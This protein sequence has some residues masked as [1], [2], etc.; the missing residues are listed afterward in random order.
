MYRDTASSYTA[1]NEAVHGFVAHVPKPWAAAP[2]EHFVHPAS[3]PQ[4]GSSWRERAPTDGTRRTAE[5][6]RQGN[7]Y[8]PQHAVDLYQRSLVVPCLPNEIA[9]IALLPSGAFGYMTCND[10]VAVELMRIERQQPGGRG[11]KCLAAVRIPIYGALRG[12]VSHMHAELGIL[13]CRP[14]RQA[15]KTAR[16][17]PA[18][19]MAATSIPHE[20][21][22]TGMKTASDWDLR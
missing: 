1:S 10:L 18:D 17:P 2:A 22:P 8:D 11:C 4:P 16:Q 19:R 9:P 12:C 7:S 14:R 6:V 21:P 5:Q 13:N 20:A 15:A 3:V